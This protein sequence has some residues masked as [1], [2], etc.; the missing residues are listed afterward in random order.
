MTEGTKYDADKN[1]LDLIPVEVLEAVGKIYTM[2][3]AKYNDENWRKGISYK[4]IYGALLRHLFAWWRGEELDKESGY[5]HLWHALWGIIALVY[6]HLYP[7]K[8]KEFDNR[9]I[10]GDKNE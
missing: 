9:V 5:S 8:Y 10:V 6:Y 4:R 3:A 2:G 1:R 7:E